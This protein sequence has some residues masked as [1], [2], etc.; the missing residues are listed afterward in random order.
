MESSE[1]L[2]ETLGTYIYGGFQYTRWPVLYGHIDII[3]SDI[4]LEMSDLENLHVP[5]SI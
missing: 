4:I 5:S 2:L 1:N 3:N